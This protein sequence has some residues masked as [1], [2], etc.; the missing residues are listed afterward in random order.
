[1]DATQ[2]H[3]IGILEGELARRNATIVELLL[4]LRVSQAR[5]AQ[6]D[7]AVAQNKELRR[8][9]ADAE[10]QLFAVTKIPADA[11]DGK[12]TAIAPP[13][14]A[15]DATSNKTPP[16]AGSTTTPAS[17]VV[18]PSAPSAIAPPPAPIVHDARLAEYQRR[19]AALDDSPTTVNTGGS[20]AGKDGGASRSQPLPLRAVPALDPQDEDALVDSIMDQC[21][22]DAAM[23]A[24]FE[25]VEEDDL[26]AR[27]KRLTAKKP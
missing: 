2:Q 5:A 22:D 4:Q 1:M 21:L 16:V 17:S 18:S 24:V 19:L 20:T 15:V 3:R 14:A 27:Y 12:S 23:D 7:E 26:A 25:R 8:R 9:L 6:Y 11:I 13:A 10:L